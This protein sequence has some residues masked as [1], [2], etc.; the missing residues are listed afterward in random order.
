MSLNIHQM[1][2]FRA[3]LEAGSIT[4]AASMLRISQP[5]VSKQLA[6][7]EASLGTPLVDR[8]PRGVRA[9]AAGRLLAEHARRI[10]HAERDA[11]TALAEFLGLDQGY[12]AVGASTTVGNYLVPRVLGDFHERYPGVEVELVVSNTALI[13]RA[14]LDGRLDVG[15]TEGFAQSDAL[16]IEV[17][18]QDELVC[19]VH[20]DHA[21]A[22]SGPTS[23]TA[24]EGLPVI[25]RERGSGTRAVVEAA[26]SK[27]GV[28]VQPAMSLGSTEAVKTAVAQGL[29]AA[30]VS[31]LTID[32]ELELGTLC[33]VSLTDLSLPRSLHRL[34][35]KGNTVSPAAERYLAL[36]SECYHCGT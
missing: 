19:I 23:V 10:F 2:V 35:L 6:E 11:E 28:Q 3:V 18:A 22:K 5:A 20:P 21:L 29:G 14:V 26:F 34:T 7:F 4:R 31:R 27:H 30:L 9:T 1:R 16:N 24:L 15:L 12:L 13:Q 8:L 25:F 33:L 32:L 17:F 36:L